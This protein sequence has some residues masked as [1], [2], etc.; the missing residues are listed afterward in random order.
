[1]TAKKRA[2]ADLLSAIR[3]TL[4]FLG[5]GLTAKGIGI[6]L[7]VSNKRAE[8]LLVEAENK[9][10]VRQRQMRSEAV[11]FLIPQKGAQG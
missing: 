7:D 8:R 6:R 3:S 1:M 4:R 10:L 11:W 9:G 2:D 5:G